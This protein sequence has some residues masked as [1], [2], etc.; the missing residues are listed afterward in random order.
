[1][2]PCTIPVTVS[3]VFTENTVIHGRTVDAGGATPEIGKAV[4]ESWILTSAR[5]VF[6]GS[7]PDT[8]SDVFAIVNV[9]G[10]PMRL[11]SAPKNDTDP[12]Q[13]SADEPE[14][15][16]EEFLI[17]TCSVS[18]GDKLIGGSTITRAGVLSNAYIKSHTAPS[19]HGKR[20]TGPISVINSFPVKADCPVIIRWLIPLIT[21]KTS[22]ENTKA[23]G[24]IGGLGVEEA[25]P[26]GIS[27]ISALRT[28]GDT[29][30]PMDA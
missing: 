20:E 28:A 30:L 2:Y 8:L 1:M 12:A 26:S 17:S 18:V 24:G 7:L 13:L 5:E 22:T 15:I 19:I 6:P 21:S 4:R 9:N 10:D 25:V 14:Y 23:Q 27:F 11:P 16:I 29:W 3:T